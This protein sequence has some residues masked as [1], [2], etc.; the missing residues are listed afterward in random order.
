[1]NQH[2]V[3]ILLILLAL[4]ILAS[5]LPNINFSPTDWDLIRK[6]LVGRRPHLEFWGQAFIILMTISLVVLFG[7]FIGQILA[8]RKRKKE[9]VLEIY[10][11]PIKVPWFMYIFLILLGGAL[12]A[13]LW[14]L[15]QQPPFIEEKII[16]PAEIDFIPEKGTKV[17]AEDSRPSKLAWAKFKESELGRYFLIG[18]LIVGLCWIFLFW[19][20]KRSKGGADLEPNIPEIAARA[21]IDLEKGTNLTDV[22][23]RCYRDMCAILQQK[24]ALRP[25]MTAREFAQHLQ[26]AG[27]GG[28]E[29]SR[30]TSLF[31][32]VRYGRWVA[33][34]EERMEALRL[35]KTI[36]DQY[37]KAV[38]AV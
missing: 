37:G 12:G 27:V 9:P 17:I 32:K 26:E 38:D 18:S 21:V 22:I 23:L 11:E 19:L 8:K 24:V 28:E 20:I 31:E 1:M 29:V 34:S 35:L 33:N 14:H 2:R 4:W 7:R 30:L 5:A 10:R 6:E 15:S 36:R 25:E 13:G 3:Y 16:R